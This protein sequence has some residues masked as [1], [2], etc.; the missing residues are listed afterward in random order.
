MNKKF[1]LFRE[2]YSKIVYKSY[3]IIDEDDFIKIVYH[4]EIPSL[5]IFNPYLVISKKHILNENIDSS[6]LN[7]IVF[8]LGLIELISYYKCVC[9]K[10][11]EIEAGFIDEYEQRWFKK[12]F[13]NGLGEFF[14]VN[15]IKVSEDELFDFVITG[16]KIDI[17]D[18]DYNGFG[19]LI[20]IGGG[21]DSNVT[22]ELLKGYDNKCFII[23]PK[24]VHLEC[25]G[26]I[27]SYTVK[28]VIDKNLIDLNSLGYLNGHTP[29][30]A[31][32]AF[33]SYLMAYLSNRKY[34]VLLNEGSANEP[35][36]IGTNI[37]HQYSKTFEFEKD[38]Y[39]YTKKYFKIDIKYFSLLRPI[40]EI[41]IAY[42]FTKYKK[43]HKIFR[44]CNVGSKENPWIW[45]ANCPKCLFVFI[46]LRAF[47]SEKEV[48]DIFG[49]NMLDNKKMEKY[50][51]EL[52]GAAETKPFECIG[53]IEEVNYAMNRI[54]KDDSSYL[55][56]LYKEKYYKKVD[57]DLSKIYYEHNVSDEYLELLKEAIKNAE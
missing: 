27:E 40:K 44:S 52:I 42:L 19:N 7:S 6:L 55:T 1:D 31:I 54:S 18:V 49:E 10:T 38:F 57:I 51:L 20:P 9:P 53:T 23:N 17:K 46:I 5:R 35:T 33:T 22:L 47:M 25:A 16:K 39:E 29:F 12:L 37:N 4:F 21:K 30:S 26:E 14:H 50:F 32:V 36:V 24:Q 28:R 45:C 15:D 43:Y 56:N 48:T 13:F 11:I 3:Q 41:Q 8:R 2:K 34:I